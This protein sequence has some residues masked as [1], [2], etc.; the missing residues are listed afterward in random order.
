MPLQTINIG[1]SANDGTGD[2]L[3]TAGLKIND[4]FTFTANQIQN[5][6]NSSNSV[7]ITAQA[8][9]NKANATNLLS[10]VNSTNNFNASV[11]TDKIILVDN[12][13]VGSNV[14]INLPWQN[15]QSGKE[16]IVKTIDA[17][18]FQTFIGLQSGANANY[19][20]EI[21]PGN[22]FG[23]SCN[24]EVT[25]STVHFAYDGDSRTYRIL[26]YYIP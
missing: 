25:G 14:Y 6:Y 22:F 12:A 18:S 16:Y 4:N 11:S 17:G 5:V 24:L 10:K 21:I 23:Y 19:Y 13:D 15:V 20:I 7:S 26:N 2:P 8:A 3:R 9:F 1:S